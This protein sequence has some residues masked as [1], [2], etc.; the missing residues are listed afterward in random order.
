M[1][2]YAR[3]IFPRLCDRAMRRP[4]MARLRG[5]VLVGVGGDVLEIGFGTGL[6]LAYY[7]EHVRRITAVDPNPGMTGLAR[8]RIAGAGIEV[9][10]RALGGEALPF[11]DETFDCVVST[12]TLCSIAEVGR[13]LG[14]VYRV[15]RP[16]GRFLFLEHGLG[17]DPGVRRWQRRLTPIQRRL[18]D[19]CRLDLDVEAVVRGQ[20]FGH[21]EVDRF[22]LERTPRLL[23]SMYRGVA[24]R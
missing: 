16:G 24:T 21:V 13:A 12:W 11:E 2:L 1:G 3:H 7:P 10:L 17:D 8:R 22:L 9:D 18:A 4:D 14:E 23:G 15:L 6:N 5:E 20:P 19:G